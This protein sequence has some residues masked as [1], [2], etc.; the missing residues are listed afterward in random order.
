MGDVN[1]SAFAVAIGL[2]AAGMAH[3][4]Q[5]EALELDSVVSVPLLDRVFLFDGGDAAAA[6]PY[7]AR[8]GLVKLKGSFTVAS[9]HKLVTV[10]G[11]DIK[12]HEVVIFDFSGATVLDDSAA[13]VIDR[14]M[15]IAT[16]EQTEFIMM[17]MPHN[18]REV[19][20]TLGILQKVP[21]QRLVESL[22]E[23]RQVAN[24]IL[25]V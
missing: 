8:A 17:G 3:A 2:I 4:R 23:A 5:L 16:V 13:M 6:D 21:A 20:Q 25:H 22:E 15:D 7:S 24:D 12:D 11:A 18:V 19:L 9:A 14:L 10:I 1:T